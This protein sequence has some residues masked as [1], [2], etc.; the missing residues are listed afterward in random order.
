VVVE[1]QEDR[2]EDV[3]QRL[4]DVRY[5]KHGSGGRRRRSGLEQPLVLDGI[6]SPVAPG[7]TS[8]QPPGG[9]DKAS[10]YAESTNRLRGVFRAGRVVA[11]ALSERR[12][13]QSLIQPD[14]QDGE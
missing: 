5:D 13:N 7:V 14:R 12:R 10:E 6:E 1:E 8:E 3:D 11:A 2:L 4:E 9:Q